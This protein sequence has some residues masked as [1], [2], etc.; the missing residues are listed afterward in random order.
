MKGVEQNYGFMFCG[1]NNNLLLIIQLTGKPLDQHYSCI[2]KIYILGG[3]RCMAN[4]VDLVCEG[5]PPFWY[6]TKLTVK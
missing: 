6:K 5:Q 2:Y 3:N 1:L 4:N